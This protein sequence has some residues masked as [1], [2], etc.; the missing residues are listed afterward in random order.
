[1]FISLQLTSQSTIIYEVLDFACSITVSK[2]QLIAQ[3]SRVTLFAGILTFTRQL[4]LDKFGPDQI[5]DDI[6]ATNDPYT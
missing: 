4:V 5:R 1:M 2:A 6:F 3:T